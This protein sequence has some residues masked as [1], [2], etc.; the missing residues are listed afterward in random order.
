MNTLIS[1]MKG[2]SLLRINQ[3]LTIYQGV[4]ITYFTKNEK[5]QKRL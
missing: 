5:V 1:P 2:K 4:H 3:L